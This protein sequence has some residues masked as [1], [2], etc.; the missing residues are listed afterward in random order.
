MLKDTDLSL[1]AYE[2]EKDNALKKVLT[3]DNNKTANTIGMMIG[4]EG[5]FSQKEIDYASENGI[6]IV[7]LGNRILRTETAA[8]AMLSCIMYEMNEL[9]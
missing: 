5:G 2:C 7:S 3:D 9:G 1:L 6:N 4:P 8:V